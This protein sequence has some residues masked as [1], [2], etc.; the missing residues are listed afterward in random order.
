MDRPP[1]RALD[2]RGLQPVTISMFNVTKFQNL[3]KGRFGSDLRFFEQVA[4][5]NLIAADLARE[6]VPE[7]TVVL[8]ESQTQGRGRNNHSWYSPPGVN[9]YF[10]IIL[11]PP[12]ERLHYLPYIVAL[13]VSNSLNDLRIP[14]DL[15]WP[16]DILIDGKKVAGI[17]IQTSMEENRL[18]F[19]LSGIGINV[20]ASNFPAEIS[21][22]AG[23]VRD[24]L[25]RDVERENLLASILSEFEQLYARISS[26]K[27]SDLAAMVSQHSSY[28]QGCEV[29]IEQQGKTIYGTTA[30][31]DSMGG[32]IVRTES[33]TES[34]YTGEITSCRRR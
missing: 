31:L 22:T 12:S 7:G 19:A 21:S 28:V 33:G 25:G 5:T 15:K 24:R 13:S 1:R 4:S 9:L 23:S 26:M 16:N 29:Q 14:C 18:Q 11:Y 6:N 3:R 10:T 27:W 8:A 32:L 30:G 17:L 34:F 2:F 20:N